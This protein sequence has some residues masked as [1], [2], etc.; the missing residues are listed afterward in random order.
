MTSSLI[1]L[2]ITTA[3]LVGAL[4]G[5]WF[6][7]GMVSDAS[8]HAAELSLAIETKTSM[9]NRAAQV[10]ATLT[11]LADDEEILQKYFVAPTD[12]VPFLEDLQARGNAAG[13][14]VKV[15]S[16]SA[17]PRTGAPSALQVALE[18]VGTFAAV[19]NTIGRIEYAPYNLS[20]AA[21][22]LSQVAASATGPS[23]EASPSWQASII[24]SV[25]STPA[26]TSSPVVA[27]A[28][29]NGAGT[30]RPL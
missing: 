21:L 14:M 7:Y 10:R 15:L 3:L 2:L 12:V 4:V 19:M 24:L 9:T 1:R 29:A 17:G 20:I 18:V 8:A 16:V 30:A 27:P 25:G 5:Y 13:T 22:T 28:P 6:W 23:A 26:A 11:K